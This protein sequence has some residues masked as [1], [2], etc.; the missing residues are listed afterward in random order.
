MP[1]LRLIVSL[2]LSVAACAAHAEIAG[3]KVRIGVLTDLSG[4][5]E[6]ASGAGS[7]EG[8]RMAAEEF[9]GKVNGKPVEI[10]SGDHQNKPDLGAAIANRWFDIDKVDA[11]TDLVNSSVAFAVLASTRP[12]VG[13]DWQFQTPNVAAY[14]DRMSGSL[15][16]MLITS[17]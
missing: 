7:V 12:R 6:T 15:A 4:A 5:Y 10:L 8:A 2:A 13:T 14:A 9:G 17:Q 1:T 11:I 3:D 16:E